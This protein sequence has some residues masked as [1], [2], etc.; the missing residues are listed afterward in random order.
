MMRHVCIVSNTL[1]DGGAERWASNTCSYLA[2]QHDL[3]VSLILFR[4]EQSYPCPD[5]VCV[6]VLNHRYFAHTFR[7]IRQ[8][9]QILIQDQVDVVISNGAFTGQFVGQAVRGTNTHW[10][11][12]ISGNIAK[13]QQNVLQRLGWRWLDRNIRRATAIVTNSTSLTR[14]AQSRWRELV[15]RAI[16]IPNG[17]DVKYLISASNEPQ[18]LCENENPPRQILLSAGRLHSIKRPDIFL[19]ATFLL[20]KSFDLQAY[21]C[22]DGPLRSETERLVTELGLERRV[23]ILGF[24][25]DLPAWMRRA[26]CFVMTSDH[27]G[28]PNVLAE[29]M[30]LGVPVV[31]TQCD[32]GPGELLADGR[33]WLAP[34]GDSAKIAAAIA[35]VLSNPDEAQRRASKAQRWVQENLDLAFIGARWKKLIDDCLQSQTRHGENPAGRIV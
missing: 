5:S 4:N 1:A 15:E 28:S 11:A 22:G 25:S 12:R 26:A 35:E 10:I 19:Q 16:T 7:T 33:G 2:D 8:L 34:V 20:Q 17:V 27:E 24:R 9:R 6:R 30:A 3:N 14:E 31:S 23:R 32:H 21:W 29:A 18:E 13:G